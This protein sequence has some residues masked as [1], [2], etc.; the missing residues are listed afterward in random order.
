MLYSDFALYLNKF[1]D[2]QA[3]F[4]FSISVVVAFLIFYIALL[5]AK[6]Y[7]KTLRTAI[8]KWYSG[9]HLTKREE[10]IFYEYQEFK[11]KV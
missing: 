7:D 1:I 5:S 9:Q 11:E 4:C 10:R 6:R 3:L 8:D 2:T